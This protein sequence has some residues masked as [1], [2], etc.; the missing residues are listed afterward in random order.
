M[1]ID[2][3]KFR[4]SPELFGSIQKSKPKPIGG[5]K[6]E[7]KR[8]ATHPFIRGP[9]QHDWIVKAGSISRREPLVVGLELWYLA[10]LG[11]STDLIVFCPKRC[12]SYGLGVR[13]A[14]R[15]LSQLERAGLVRVLRK[16][17]ACPRVDIVLI[18]S[19]ESE[20]NDEKP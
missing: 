11:S 18:E 10:G 7:R 12:E 8:K 15:G 9:I 14:M 13:G 16:R 1:E 5:H 3:E 20:A 17:G 19:Q 6:R 2:L 4:L